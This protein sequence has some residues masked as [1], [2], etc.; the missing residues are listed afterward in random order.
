MYYLV[1]LYRVP[2]RIRYADP[3]S[4]GFL[5]IGTANLLSGIS[6]RDSLE[7]RIV[8]GRRGGG[9]ERMLKYL[10]RPY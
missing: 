3:K 9:E 6:V 1:Y 2:G 4:D 7:G 5:V 8:W 10:S